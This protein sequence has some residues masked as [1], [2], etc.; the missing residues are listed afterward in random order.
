MVSATRALATAASILDRLR[1]MPASASSRSTSR[2]SNS[3]TSAMEKPANAVRNAGRLR[4]MISHDRPDWNASRVSRS[5]I[6][7]SPCSGVPHSRSW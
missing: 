3:A 4:R 1:T 2:S 6:A 7:L 5:N